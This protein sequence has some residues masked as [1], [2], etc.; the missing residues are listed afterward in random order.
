MQWCKKYP[1][2]KASGRSAETESW[3]FLVCELGYVD[4]YD[5]EQMVRGDR[6][7]VMSLGRNWLVVVVTAHLLSTLSK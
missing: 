1:V 6:R 5:W 3:V 4:R 7:A 2:L